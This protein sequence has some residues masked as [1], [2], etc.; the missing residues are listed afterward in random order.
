MYEFTGNI[1]G[2][3]FLT[4]KSEIKVWKIQEFGLEAISDDDF[5]NFYINFSY[6]ILHVRKNG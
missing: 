1:H 2:G 3:L 5:G 4:I 6:L